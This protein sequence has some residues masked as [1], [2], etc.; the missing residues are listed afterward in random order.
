MWCLKNFMGL[1]V[2]LVSVAQGAGNCSELGNSIAALNVLQDIK[3]RPFQQSYPTLQFAD[4]TEY[5]IRCTDL[6]NP[7]ALRPHTICTCGG[8]FAFFCK[9][10]RGW[11]ICGPHF[12]VTDGPCR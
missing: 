12:Q 10:E 11:A 9:T 7:D 1:F 6:T 4:C 5:C 3:S 2:L 8:V